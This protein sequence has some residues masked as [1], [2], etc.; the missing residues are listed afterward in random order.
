MSHMIYSSIFLF[1]VKGLHTFASSKVTLSIF[2]IFRILLGIF[3]HAFIL[4]MIH[5][6]VMKH[7]LQGN[8]YE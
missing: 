3:Y 1:N 5:L 8:A 6:E 4:H 7:I 2:A